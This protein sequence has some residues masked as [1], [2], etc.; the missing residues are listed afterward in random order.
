MTFSRKLLLIVGTTALAFILVITV[1]LLTARRVNQQI[2]SI[3]ARYVPMLELAPKLEAELEQLRNAFRDAVAAQDLDALEAT[4]ELEN[5]LLANVDGARDVMRPGDAASLRSSIDNYYDSAF[6]V[7]ARLIKGETGEALVD[8]MA[9]MQSAHARAERELER[10][11]AIDRQQLTGAFDTVRLANRA[12]GWLR[13]SIA[14]VCLTFVL[15]LSLWISRG[16]LR[17]LAELSEGFARFGEGD[18]SRP[19]EILSADELG[20]AAR[21]ANRMADKLHQSDQQRTAT[22]WIKSGQAGLAV[23][24]QGELEPAEVARRSVRFLARHLGSP[25]ATFYDVVEARLVPLG[26][27]GLSDTKPL[28][29]FARGEGLIG[30]AALQH[31][32]L[33]L[34]EPPPDALR[35]RSSMVD[36]P[37]RALV[38]VPLIHLGNVIAVMELALMTALSR[39]TTDFLLAVRDTVATALEVARGQAARRELLAQTQRQASMLAEQ[40]ERLRDANAD[41]S[42]ANEGL[43]QQTAELDSFSYS[44]SHDLRAPL[45]AIDGFTRILI[46]DHGE[47]L[48]A[49]GRRITEVIRNNTQKM[50]RLIDDL[51]AFSRLGR[52]AVKQRRIDMTALARSAFE[53]SSS[54]EPDRKIRLEMSDLPP[55][56]GDAALLEQ[57]WLNLMTNAV[58]YTRN[59]DEAVIEVSGKV[60]EGE[61]IY[62]VHDNGVGFDMKYVDK[63]F[64]VFQRL[65][66]STEF[67]GTGVGLAL[68][69]RVV[70]RHKGRVWAESVKDAGA[71][72]SFAL[73]VKE[74]EHDES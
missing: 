2:E 49:E 34:D 22:E 35:V 46:E 32:I 31:E 64:G 16:V 1:G 12:A 60:V 28:P 54:A 45:R 57:V 10:T 52:Q 5:K 40:E 43:Q 69:S 39:D 33:I 56:T 74:V 27:Y 8:A 55:T 65:H 7:S 41:L 18:F 66:T 59:M 13:I 42:R 24:L 73:P 58:K 21:S 26:H 50:G 53:E 29:G 17:S 6:A 3:E 62:S 9:Q 14:V 11:T 19:M 37:P 20:D 25:A 67:E 70:K 4:V 47:N 44:V 15:G 30:E 38:V 51:L 72:F 68:V 63:L 23:E 36:G 48:D 71:T 61:V